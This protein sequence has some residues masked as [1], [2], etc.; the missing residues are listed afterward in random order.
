MLYPRPMV[1][2][3]ISQAA[4]S[5][6]AAT[7]RISAIHG[8]NAFRGAWIAGVAEF[9]RNDGESQELFFPGWVGVRAMLCS[10]QIASRSEVCD[11][12]TGELF[13]HC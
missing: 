8:R 12:F 3:S 1:L 9:A 10:L 2:A 4:A 6:A 7:L 13:G 5:A 11:H